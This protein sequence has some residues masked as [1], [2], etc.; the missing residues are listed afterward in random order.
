M[1]NKFLRS[2]IH[3]F[4]HVNLSIYRLYFLTIFRFHLMCVTRLSFLYLIMR[5]IANCEKD[6]TWQTRLRI[7]GRNPH[8][9]L[10]GRKIRT[11]LIL[12]LI[13][14]IR[15]RSRGRVSASST[16]RRALSPAFPD[17]CKIDCMAQRATLSYNLRPFRFKSYYARF[18][19]LLIHILHHTT[20]FTAWYIIH[21][22]VPISIK[23]VSRLWQ[24]SFGIQNRCKFVERFFLSVGV[25]TCGRCS[26]SHTGR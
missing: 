5:S 21:T 2:D 9:N 15:D 17:D 7:A 23:I 1:T 20:L 12:L 4:C 6:D 26:Y 3:R 11:L 24:R 25:I 22:Y 14:F 18:S 8:T 16:E 10:H 13:S 19:R